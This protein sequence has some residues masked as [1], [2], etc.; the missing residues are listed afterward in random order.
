MR[1]LR[2]LSLKLNLSIIIL[3]SKTKR[4]ISGVIPF[5]SQECDTFLSLVCDTFFFLF[6]S[7]ILFFLVSWVWYIF[8]VSSVIFFWVS[9]F[10]N[11]TL[12]NLTFWISTSVPSKFKICSIN[13]IYR[14]VLEVFWLLYITGYNKNY[15]YITSN[16]LNNQY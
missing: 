9:K 7:V 11:V 8:C 13:M 5:L 14:T 15:R 10:S 4:K 16:R 6:L 3:K 1:Y 12:S 2:M